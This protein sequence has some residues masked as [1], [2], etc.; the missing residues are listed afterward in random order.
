VEKILEGWNN[1]GDYIPV[2]T[3]VREIDWD[4]SEHGPGWPQLV[5]RDFD[6]NQM[7]IPEQALQKLLRF[8]NYKESPMDAKELKNLIA[9][10]LAPLNPDQIGVVIG[11]GLVIVSVPGH[12]SNRANEEMIRQRL[13]SQYRDMQAQFPNI[14]FI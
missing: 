9:G 8:V 12:L 1:L 4:W 6:G 10:Y 2:D 7:Q 13:Y 5:L 3:D 11:E 14:R